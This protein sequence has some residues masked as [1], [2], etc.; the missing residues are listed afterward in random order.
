M[1]NKLNI[2]ILITS[3][4]CLGYILFLV[5]YSLNMEKI[6]VINVFAEIMTIPII[7]ATVFFFFFNLYI[8]IRNKFKSVSIN[9]LS[10]YVQLVCFLTMFFAD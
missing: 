3:I 7:I 2:L 4:L 1:K 10:F 5:Y 9:I 6:N 8:L